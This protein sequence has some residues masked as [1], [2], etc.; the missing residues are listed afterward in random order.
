M[1]PPLTMSKA[2]SDHKTTELQLSD[3]IKETTVPLLCQ[4]LKAASV[5]KATKVLLKDGT[6]EITVTSQ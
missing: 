3:G 5:L 1:V 4:E 2:D 6:K